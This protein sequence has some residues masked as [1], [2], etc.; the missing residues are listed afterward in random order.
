M[1]KKEREREKD[2]YKLQVV[3]DEYNVNST[4]PEYTGQT[5][6]FYL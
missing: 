4:P 1:L 6:V 3:S 2:Y 5:L